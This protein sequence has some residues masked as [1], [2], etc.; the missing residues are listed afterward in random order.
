MANSYLKYP[1]RDID[2][3]PAEDTYELL[4]DTNFIKIAN[5]TLKESV[6]RGT[7]QPWI[8]NKK[9]QIDTDCTIIH[10]EGVIA[11]I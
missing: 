9:I 7:E 8:C 2:S 1:S 4:V 3:I 11:W 6:K 10:T 5:W